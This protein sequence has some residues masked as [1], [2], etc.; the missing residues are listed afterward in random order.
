MQDYNKGKIYKI[1][2]DSCLLPYIG[3]TIDT[4]EYRFRKHITKYKSWK[5]GKSN[6]NTSFEILKYDDARIELIENYP[7]NSREELEKQEGTYIIIGKN[8]VNKQKAGR[9][10]DYKEYH[11]KWYKNPENKKR[12]TE[13]QK[14]PAIKAYRSEKIEC[15]CG[16]FISRTNLKNH[17][18][19]S[20]HKL[21]L[22]N[23]E[24]Y[25]KLK[26]RLKKENEDNPKYKC[27]CGSEI[28][29]QTSKIKKHKKTKKHIDLMNCKNL[30]LMNYKIKTKGGVLDK[31]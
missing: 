31:V 5:N 19:S 1:I 30:D 21:F 7:C 4:I 22:E 29:N 16:E 6:Y 26:N 20:Q 14:A 13:L 18:K 12:Q 23:P 25:K 17:R 10:G 27:E 3:S 9:N 28:N 15:D 8:C 11:K 24:E 2:S